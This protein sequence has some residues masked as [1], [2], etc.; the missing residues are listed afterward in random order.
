MTTVGCRLSQVLS[1][2]SDPTSRPPG[3]QSGNQLRPRTYTLR[4]TPSLGRNSGIKFTLGKI[5]TAKGEGEIKTLEM[6]E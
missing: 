5:T 3:L 2:K 4:P 6:N 1:G